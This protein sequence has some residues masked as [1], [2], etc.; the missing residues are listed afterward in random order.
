MKTMHFEICVHKLGMDLID[1][2]TGEIFAAG[3]DNINNAFN[4]LEVAG[5]PYDIRIDTGEFNQQKFDEALEM[6]F[7]DH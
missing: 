4:L 7:G 3:A 6:L 2:T 5:V 1:R